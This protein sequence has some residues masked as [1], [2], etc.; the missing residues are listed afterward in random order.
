MAVRHDLRRIPEDK[1]KK[2]AF[3]LAEEQLADPRAVSSATA[4]RRAEAPCLLESLPLPTSHRRSS[5]IPPRC[6]DE[7][8]ALDVWLRPT[9]GLS[10]DRV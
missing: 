4:A 1:G 6:Q 9:L 10:R 8:G 7:V 3:G 5:M 2:G